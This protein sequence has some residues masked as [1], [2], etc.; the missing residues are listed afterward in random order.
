[1]FYSHSRLTLSFSHS[2]SLTHTRTC[3]RIHIQR[4]FSNIFLSFHII[5][6]DYYISFYFVQFFP[7]KTDTQMHS[8]IIGQKSMNMESKSKQNDDTQQRKMVFLSL[9]LSHPPPRDKVLFLFAH[10]S[11]QYFNAINRRIE[12]SNELS[13]Y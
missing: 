12:V 7:I 1:M 3:T 9:S 6:T 13:E 4:L 5:I 10:H 11:I 8:H 2:H